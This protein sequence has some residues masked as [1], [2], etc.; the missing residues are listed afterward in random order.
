MSNFMMRHHFFF[1][2]DRYCSL[3]QPSLNFQEEDLTW[4][5]EKRGHLMTDKSDKARYFILKYLM[6]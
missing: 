2:L 3:M 6:E 5:I 1:V 4:E